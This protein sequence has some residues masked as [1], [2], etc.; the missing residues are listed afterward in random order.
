MNSALYL[1]H[2][3]K[4]VPDRI[5]KFILRGLF[6]LILWKLAYIFYLGPSAILDRP[7]TFRVGEQT[8]ALLNL[9]TGSSSFTSHYQVAGTIAAH[10][11]LGPP[12]NAVV[13]FNGRKVITIAN[14]CN[15]LEL[16]ILY[17]GFL[18][19]FPATFS[20]KL[21]YLAI[22]LPAIHVANILR[23][24]ALGYIGIWRPHLIEIAHHYVFK[25]VVYGLILFLW[26]HFTS[27]IKLSH[28]PA[29][30]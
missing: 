6:L 16:F 21:A 22:G 20:R 26:W 12:A 1:S 2:Q 10:N 9:L 18:L 29:A 3:W 17:A 25:I 14:A 11:Q 5:R 24:A 30:A 15:G 19:C 8:T 7:L 23:C 13:D 4:Q 28:A 27:R